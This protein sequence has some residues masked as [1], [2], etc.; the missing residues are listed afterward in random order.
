[1]LNRPAWR[2][3]GDIN[4]ITVT[5]NV[6]SCFVNRDLKIGMLTQAVGTA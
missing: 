5:A 2:I 3:N 1:M 6:F 4:G